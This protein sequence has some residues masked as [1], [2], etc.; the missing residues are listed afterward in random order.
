MKKNLDEISVWKILMCHVA[1]CTHSLTSNTYNKIKYQSIPIYDFSSGIR[2]GLQIMKSHWEFPI[3]LA[4]MVA[5]CVR[6]NQT[7]I[8]QFIYSHTARSSSPSA[9]GN[10]NFDRHIKF[11]ILFPH[12]FVDCALMNTTIWFDEL[13][14][15]HGRLINSGKFICENRIHPNTA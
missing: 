1:E 12:F 6:S 11:R 14:G 13:I 3:R 8:D 2:P 15:S 7:S 10:G 9:I 4:V 5:L